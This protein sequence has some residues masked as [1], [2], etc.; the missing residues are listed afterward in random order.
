M[1]VKILVIED[2]P[3]IADNI[4]FAFSAEKIKTVWKTTGREGLEVFAKG[5]FDLIVLDVGLPDTDG[6]ELCREIR[7]TSRIPIL[8]LTARADEVDRVVGLELGADDYMVKPFS[9]RE[10][11]ARAKA[12]LRRTQPIEK[13]SATKS[14]GHFMVNEDGQSISYAGKPLPLS[15]HEYLLLKALL[16][17]PGQVYSREKLME[18]AWESP[19]SSQTRTV[20][21]HIKSLR[22]KLKAVKPKLDPLLTHRGFGYSIQVKE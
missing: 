5:G 1:P 19:E 9:P 22:K 20:D 3:A 15:K 21:A 18:M 16:S 4:L 6:F 13:E 14:H 8:F 2:E 11:V 10:L 12:I 17:R 7:K